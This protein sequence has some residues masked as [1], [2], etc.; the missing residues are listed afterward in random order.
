M[1]KIAWFF[2]GAA[3]GVVVLAQYR[4]NPKLAEAVDTS[5]RAVED[6][7]DSVVEGYRNREAELRGEN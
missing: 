2:V 1:S 5:R 7:K 6:F 3:V 4:D